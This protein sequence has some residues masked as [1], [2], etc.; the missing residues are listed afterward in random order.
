MII[1]YLLEKISLYI[2]YRAACAIPD[3]AGPSV[4]VTGGTYTLN[5]VSRYDRTGWVEDLAN[6]TEGRY[7]H[8]CAGYMKD[9][10]LVSR[11]S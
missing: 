7:R 4:V 3:P 1:H 5:T 8:G 10:E 6:L 11:Y 2:L 9:G